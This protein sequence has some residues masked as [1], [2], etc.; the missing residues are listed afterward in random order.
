MGHAQLGAEAEMHHVAALIDELL[1]EIGILTDTARGGM[2]QLLCLI[3]DLIQLFGGDVHPVLIAFT[4]DDDMQRDGSN[5][6]ALFQILVQVA[7]DIRCDD[8]L[9]AHILPPVRYFDK[10]RK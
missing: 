7:C 10:I 2:R 3:K 1:E 9:I 4:A 6:V 5:A 8:N